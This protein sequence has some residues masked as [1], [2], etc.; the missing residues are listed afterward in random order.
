MKPMLFYASCPTRNLSHYMG[1]TGCRYFSSRQNS[2]Q[3][4]RV[5]AVSDIKSLTSG[6]SHEKTPRWVF[7]LELPDKDSN[8]DTMDQNHVSYH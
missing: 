7:F 4:L 1:S 3:P 5:L 6:S 2:S 8:L